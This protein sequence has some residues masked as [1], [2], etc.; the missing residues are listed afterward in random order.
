VCYEQ[1]VADTAAPDPGLL[2]HLYEV[3]YRVVQCEE[4]LR[5]MLEGQ[6]DIRW[7][8]GDEAVSAALGDHLRTDD[9][10]VAT[11]RRVADHVSRPDVPLA[12]LFAG[13]LGGALS[14]AVVDVSVANGLGLA[15]QLDGVDR[16]VAVR[17]DADDVD[18]VD[19]AVDVAREWKLPVVFIG[20]CER[21]GSGVAE[22]DD[23]SPVGVWSAVGDA[24]ARA[25]T[26]DGPSVL[27]VGRGAGSVTG[28]RSWL[29]AAG[30]VAAGDVAA[31]EARVAAE[32]DEAARVAREAA[33]PTADSEVPA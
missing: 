5:S 17:F 4:R 28:Y 31:L 7:S 32:V 3:Q 22:G 29:V 18:R 33:G 20:P 6:A 11:S 24:V 8:S 12:E 16:V 27:D 25:R 19:Q 1:R 14:H 2:L 13:F 30:H 15:A 23:T 10:V 9:V 26:G 21:I